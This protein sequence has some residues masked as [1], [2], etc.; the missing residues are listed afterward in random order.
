ME[1]SYFE[2]PIVSKFKV[3]DYITQNNRNY[4]IIS[5][6]CVRYNHELPT[7]CECESPE[8]VKA[9]R[10]EIILHD[11]RI[12]I[13]HKSNFTKWIPLENDLCL[14]RD[15]SGR[16]YFERFS[17]FDSEGNYVSEYGLTTKFCTPFIGIIPA[18]DEEEYDFS[19]SGKY[20]S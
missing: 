17:S 10:I 18:F 11:G 20:D 19:I 16:V 2:D 9:Y 5:V 15:D 4:K 8:Y 7:E 3:N 6:E 12:I 1:N 13:E 14:F